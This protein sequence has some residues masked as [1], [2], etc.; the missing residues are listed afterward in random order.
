[1]NEKG[2][3]RMNEVTTTT[4]TVACKATK[5]KKVAINLVCGCSHRS[6]CLMIFIIR[7]LFFF[8]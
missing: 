1:M 3:R 7:N 4:F 6:E 2:R 5:N 8:I